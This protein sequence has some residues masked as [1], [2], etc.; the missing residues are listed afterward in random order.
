M[1][2]SRWSAVAFSSTIMAI[3]TLSLL[4]FGPG[5]DPQAGVA[6]VAGTMA[7]NTFVIFQFFNILNVRN[8]RL[9]VFRKETLGN[10]YLWVALFCVLG[11]QLAVTH[12]GFMQNLFDT[13][14]ISLQQWIVCVAISSTVLWA[15]EARKFL[16]R[17]TRTS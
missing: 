11:L 8:D 4:A 15:E 2:R 3:G 5:D 7:F 6:T 17:R 9:T 12:V 1:T 16:S 14:G 10:R 13:T